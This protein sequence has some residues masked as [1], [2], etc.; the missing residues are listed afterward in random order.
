MRIMSA[1]S[2][3]RS[4]RLNASR[5]FLALLLI[6]RDQLLAFG[7]CALKVGRAGARVHGVA[8]PRTLF[9]VGD[10]HVDLS[11]SADRLKRRLLR[12]VLALLELRALLVER[13]D[14]CR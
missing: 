7:A 11:G 4:R 1:A 12:R 5:K 9:F 6:E 14:N 10:S 2:S 3:P 13:P 8:Q